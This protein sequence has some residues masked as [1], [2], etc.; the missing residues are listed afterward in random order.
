MRIIFMVALWML[1]LPQL[2][3]AVPSVQAYGESVV[4][5][6]KLNLLLAYQ[7][8][9]AET[10]AKSL[11]DLRLSFDAKG[12][13]VITPDREYL[14]NGTVFFSLEELP[15]VCYDEGKVLAQ[16]KAKEGSD[17]RLISMAKSAE[18]TARLSYPSWLA[19]YEK[20][21]MRIPGAVWMYMYTHKARTIGCIAVCRLIILQI[22]KT[23][24]KSDW[25]AL[26]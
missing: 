22:I 17:I 4:Q 7:R 15:P 13:D 24:S 1:L 10:P 25:L 3:G 8:T 21:K 5:P 18:H 9:K 6:N 2:S 11:S 23:K 19:I 16:I 20:G 12:L 26:S 14:M